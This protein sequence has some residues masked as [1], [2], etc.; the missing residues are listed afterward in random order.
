MASIPAALS[1]DRLTAFLGF[2]IIS[3][4]LG[5]AAVVGAVIRLT[6][7]ITAGG[8]CFEEIRTRLEQIEHAIEDATRQN[9]EGT[10]GSMVDLASF[11]KGE[12]EKLVAAS[13]DRDAYPRLVTTMEEQPPASAGK[14]L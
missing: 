11:G 8:E 7:R 10:A 5:A 6:T 12:P 2:L 4:A 9:D 1:G 13:L 14:M 3:G